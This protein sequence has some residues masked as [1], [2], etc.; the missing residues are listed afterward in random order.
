[1]PRRR[2]ATR[3]DKSAKG[4]ACANTS[5][6]RRQSRRYLL[7]LP[8]EVLNTII[9][10]IAICDMAVLARTCKA[11]KAYIEP[12]LHQKMYTRS[13]TP[14]DTG[15]LVGLLQTRPEKLPFV[16]VLALDE[17]HPRHTRR[18]LAMCMPRL[19]CIMIQHQEG[20]W[21]HVSDREKRTLNR[22]LVQ[23]PAL[24]QMVFSRNINLA[25]EKLSRPD[26][27]LFNYSN[28]THLRLAN[29]DLSEFGNP[30]HGAFSL[31]R[32]IFLWVESPPPTALESITLSAFNGPP[33][34]E[35]MLQPIL[36]HAAPTLET[37]QLEQR[38]MYHRRPFTFDLSSFTALRLLRIEPRLLLAPFGNNR[39]TYSTTANTDLAG[40]IRRR[41]PPNLKVLL[42]NLTEPFAPR[43]DIAQVI[44][45]EDI[46]FMQC[47]LEQR[48]AV[49]PKLKGLFMYY[50][51][52]LAQ[53][54]DLSKLYT[55]AES[56]HVLMCALNRTGVVDLAWDG[57]DTDEDD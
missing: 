50:E 35:R 37:L 11:V 1:M 45:P 25:P 51:E 10:E 14:Q 56:T 54:E 53:T 57:F 34:E 17:Y 30:G 23:Q 19:W 2:R 16:E 48:D 36:P 49:A 24:T 21:V 7:D 38:G 3:A 4:K 39:G 41:L 46:E 5:I 31:P 9:E 28:L 20:E 55:L 40:L 52:N 18:L 15:G 33:I 22:A 27:R 32:L 43:P 42:L 12:R 47:L 8:S 29:V 13:G 26:I 6:S 44:F